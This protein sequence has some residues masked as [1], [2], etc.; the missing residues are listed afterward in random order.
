LQ[1]KTLTADE[2]EPILETIFRTIQ[3]DESVQMNEIRNLLVKRA[4]E[5]GYSVSSEQDP[6]TLAAQFKQQ[7]IERSYQNA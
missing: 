5:L 4:T 1:N 2:W 3:K 7:R 6:L